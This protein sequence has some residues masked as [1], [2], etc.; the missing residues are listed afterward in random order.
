MADRPKRGRPSNLTIHIKNVI[1]NLAKEGKTVLQIGNM[2]GVSHKTVY[3]WMHSDPE[4][5]HAIKEARDLAAEL[6]E[7][8]LFSRAIGFSH[9]ATKMFYDKSRRKVIKAEYT[10]HFPPDP[11][12]MIFWLK[13]RQPERWREKQEVDLTKDIIIKIDDDE[14]NL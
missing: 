14:R 1:I 3:N 4:L 6:V 9:P 5:L 12:S 8:S 13:N 11:T 2:L 7:A 10:Q